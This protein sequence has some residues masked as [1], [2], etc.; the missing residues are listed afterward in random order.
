M[1]T[2]EEALVIPALERAPAPLWWR[3]LAAI[4]TFTRRKPLGAFGALILIFTFVVALFSPWIARFPYEEPHFA[5]ALTSPNSTYWFGTDQLGRDFF[6]RMIIGSQVT[7]LAGLGTVIFAGL[8]SVVV[9]G[10]S[11]YFGGRT[12]MIAQRGV[13]IWVAL[14][15]IFLLLT[16]VSV[17]GTGG[18]GFLGIGRGPDV[19]LD[20]KDGDW[21]WYTFFRSTVVIFSLGVIF[22]GFGSRVIRGAVLAIKEN[23]YIE[24]AR[25]MGATDVRI[26]LRYILPNILPVVIV[27][28]TLNLGIAVVVEA[29]I[30]F[31]GFGI[32]APFPTWG[33]LLAKDGR[34]F[35]PDHEY[36]MLIPGAAIFIAV[37]GFNMLGDAMR[38]VL[39]PRLRGSR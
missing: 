34:V 13:D 20:P 29:T 27:L 10:L 37:Y 19:L 9:G 39:D 24:A 1:A 2:R 5:D 32:Q 23:V 38:D 28:A 7:I 11:G 30:S 14:P 25:A 21:I 18:S 17:L 36:L 12:D 31:L 16:L 6:S 22:A 3:W 4:G 8:V 33:Q 35:G 15:G 26:M